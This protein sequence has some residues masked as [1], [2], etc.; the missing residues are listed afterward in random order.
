M[1]G[2]I[3]VPIISVNLNFFF[4]ATKFN[5]FDFYCWIDP[6]INI[7]L[8]AFHLVFFPPKPLSFDPILVDKAIACVQ[9]KTKK[10]CIKQPTTHHPIE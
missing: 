9:V 2:F 7:S 3:H 1:I 10:K 8:L 4:E 5:H 6:L